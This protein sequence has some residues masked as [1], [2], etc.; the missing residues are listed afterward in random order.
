MRFFNAA[1]AVSNSY[2]TSGRTMALGWIQ[3]ITEMSIR[4]LPGVKGGLT[5]GVAD[6][7]CSICGPI[8]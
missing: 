7:I 6:E 5:A 3:P 2:K 8:V 4:N 1:I